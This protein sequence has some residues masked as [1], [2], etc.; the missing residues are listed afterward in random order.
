M[1]THKFVTSDQDGG[2]CVTGL[3]HFLEKKPAYA[4]NRGLGWSQ[5]HSGRFGE[6][7]YFGFNGIIHV[8]NF[9]SLLLSLFAVLLKLFLEL[10]R[11][12]K[13]STLYLN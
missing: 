12:C 9:V 6:A 1:Y 11:T 3:R 5:D 4:L 8:D 10:F 2:K 7:T 13:F